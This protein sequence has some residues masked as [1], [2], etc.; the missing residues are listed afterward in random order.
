M[1]DE[2]QVTGFLA[3]AQAEE[4]LDEVAEVFNRVL[5]PPQK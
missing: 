5:Q 3:A 4:V 1:A 2:L